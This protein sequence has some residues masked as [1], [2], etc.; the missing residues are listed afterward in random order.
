MRF[1]PWLTNYY[2]C[3]T[4]KNRI[5]FT[6]LN[7]NNFSF[8]IGI[9]VV[10]H[11]HGF[12]QDKRLAFLDGIAGSYQHLDH[13]TGNRRAD[14]QFA[15]GKIHQHAR[16][17]ADGTRRVY[18]NSI[19]AYTFAE[20]RLLLTLVGL[21]VVQVYGGYDRQPLSWESPRM[22]ILSRKGA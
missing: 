18:P 6:N 14:G 4:F 15:I 13:E 5:A 11:F 21:D 17:E 7:L 10:F 22:V 1:A 8:L 19:R 20:L 16:V 12:E 2:K 3:I 9:D